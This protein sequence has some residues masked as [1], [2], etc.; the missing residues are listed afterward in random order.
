MY[1]KRILNLL[2]FMLAMTKSTNHFFD[3]LFLFSNYSTTFFN[4]LSLSFY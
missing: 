3:S 1:M 2:L 4:I